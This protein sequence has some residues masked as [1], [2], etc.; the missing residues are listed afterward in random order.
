M[1]TFDGP[2]IYSRDVPLKGQEISNEIRENCDKI[3]S[4]IF[5]STFE[6]C[7]ISRMVLYFK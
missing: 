3:T 7:K 5:Y 2:E 6:Y 1:L 4:R